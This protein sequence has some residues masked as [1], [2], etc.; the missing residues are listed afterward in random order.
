[1]GMSASQARYLGLTARKSNV[2]YQGQQVNQERTALSNESANLYN[3]MCDLTVPVPPSSSDYYVT[4][5]TLDDSAKSTETTDYVLKSYVKNPDGET[6]T[7][8]LTTQET[9]K[10]ATQNIN[11]VKNIRY[12][13]EEPYKDYVMQIEGTDVACNLYSDNTTFDKPYETDSSTDKTCLK[14]TPNTIYYIDETTADLKPEGYEEAYNK[15]KSDGTLRDDEKLY[16]YQ[17]ASGNNYYFD[18]DSL[19]A[20]LNETS[21]ELQVTF[22]INDYKTNSYQAKGTINE[23]D[24]GRITSIYIY[25]TEDTPKEL[26]GKSFNISTTQEYDELGYKDAF[27]EYEYQ[28][29]VYEKAIS[30]INAKTE[31]IQAQDQQ[32]EL[33]LKQLDTEENALK[34]EMDAVKTV[35]K[36]NVEKTFNTFG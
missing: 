3:Q 22:S 10:S 13:S 14:I 8:T 24:T 11:K 35:I 6:Y 16:F 30:D 12:T 15:L 9:I 26:C 33:R 34:T 20:L 1:M 29:Y 28:K 18:E 5:Y 19:N 2:E 36:E 21:S 31:E 25:D 7:F 23:S 17:T 32:L 27:N 4:T